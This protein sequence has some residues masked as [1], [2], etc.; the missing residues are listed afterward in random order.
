MMSFLR[1]T[2]LSTAL[3]TSV[4][5]YAK[6]PERVILFMIDGLHSEAPEQ[7]D[8]PNLNA[9]I[10]EGTYIRKSCMILPHHPKVGDY[11]TFNSCSFPNPI[12]HSGTLFIDPDNRFLQEVFVGRETAFMVNATAYRSISRGFTTKIMDTALTDQEVVQHSMKYLQ[13]HNPVFMRVHLQ[14]PGDNGTKVAADTPADKPYFR[15]IFAEGSPYAAAIEAADTYLGEFVTFLKAQNLWDSTLL[16]VSSDH[17]Q[18]SHGWHPMFDEDGW[19]TPLLFVG[20]GIAKG[21]KLKAFE[22]LDLAPTIAGLFDLPAPNSNGASGIFNR[23]I[24]ATTQI[25]QNEDHQPTF[26]LNH[27]IKTYHQLKAK[28]MQLAEKDDQYFG[29]LAYLD[30]TYF[31]PEPFYHED[32]ILDWKTAGDLDHLLEAN[33]KVLA[34]MRA[35]IEDVQHPTRPG[36]LKSRLGQPPAVFPKHTHLRLQNRPFYSTS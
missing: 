27:Q 9:L 17:G 28:L 19:K 14:S 26:R 10:S 23:D 1:K 18:S 30:N 20:P 21:R 7:L 32:R 35:C 8:M 11:S 29:F 34:W 5:T 6:S 13:Q 16:I 24:L 15:D 2:I 25:P 22:H 4:M 12:L 36:F 31:T 33:D 3:I